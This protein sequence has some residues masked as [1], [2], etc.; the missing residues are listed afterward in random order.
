MEFPSGEK[1]SEAYDCPESGTTCV[2]L[3]VGMFRSQRLFLPLSDPTLPGV[4]PRLRHLPKSWILSTTRPGI[5]SLRHSAIAE[6]MHFLQR[7]HPRVQTESD[8]RGPLQSNARWS[9]CH[10]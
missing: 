1:T 9:R 7:L 2:S 8:H 6:R 4:A 10:A 5:P 3:P